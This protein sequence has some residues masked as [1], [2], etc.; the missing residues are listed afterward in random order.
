MPVGYTC[1]HVAQMSLPGLD[2]LCSGSLWRLQGES[3]NELAK[4]CKVESS[5]AE[6]LAQ[7]QPTVK[8]QTY[9]FRG[10]EG[11]VGRLRH[12]LIDMEYWWVH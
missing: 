12:A 6:R 11:P 1:L 3:N 7:N 8:S 4:I 5:S 2:K 10:A 9:L